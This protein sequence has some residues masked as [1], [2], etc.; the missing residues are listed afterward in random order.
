MAEIE[1]SVDVEV[2]VRTAYNQWPQFESAF[3]DS[4]RSL[5]WAG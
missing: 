2:D 3:R 4:R 1:A 5:E